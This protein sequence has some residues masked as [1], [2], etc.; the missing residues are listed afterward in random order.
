LL[1]GFHGEGSFSEVDGGHLGDGDNGFGDAVGTMA[2]KQI[3]TRRLAMRSWHAVLPG[4]TAE[5]LSVLP[6]L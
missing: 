2:R 3:G 1:D 5:V 6:D 4:G